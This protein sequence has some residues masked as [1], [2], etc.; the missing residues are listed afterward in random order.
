MPDGNENR[1]PRVNQFSVD[2]QR[3]IT[4]DFIVDASYIGNRGVWEPGGPLGYESQI[5]AANYAK[6]GLYPYP[7]TGP[8]GYSYAPAGVTCQAGNDCDRA[9]L[10]LPLTNPAVVAKM[11]A[12]GIS[13]ISPYPGFAG[14]TLLSALYKFPQ[15]G[16]LEPSNSPTGDSRY[17]SLQVKVT[18][19]LSRGLLAGGAYTWAKGLT[20]PT[21]QD[22]FNASGSQWS[23]QQIPPQAITMNITYTI[24]K[25]NYSFLG[26]RG[27]R[28]SNIALKDWQLGFFAQYQSGIF[29]TPPVSNVNAEFL[30]SEDVRVAGQPL[31][32]VNINNIHSYNPQTQSVLNPA[33]WAPCPTNSVCGSAAN[34]AFGPAGTQLYS[35][36]RG[37]RTPRENGNLG[38]HF[39]IKEKYDLYIR[40][41]FVNLFNRTILPNPTTTS[42]QIAPTHN[43]VGALTSGF[44]VINA[45]NAP[46]AY[47][48]PTAGAVTLLG[49]TGT[50]IAKFTF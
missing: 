29:L 33:A 50:I 16:A 35:D 1:P 26:D 40:G 47:P 43:S 49:R 25:F 24:Q 28:V 8:A 37:P 6:Y 30:P 19:R 48:A 12:A 21:P 17:D 31:Y 41:E 10:S 2:L 5:S 14:T 3:E 44:G 9:L 45:Y 36:F 23:L 39:R 32:L 15:F 11:A 7:G 22:F 27:N 20:R 18:K 38:R 42:P 4:K 13:N 46:G 34:T